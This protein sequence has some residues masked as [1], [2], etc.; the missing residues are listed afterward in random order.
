[1][2][3]LLG[4]VNASVIECGLPPLTHTYVSQTLSEPPC[5]AHGYA[6][7]KWEGI[8]YSDG[9]SLG[10]GPQFSG[11]CLSRGVDLFT[12]RVGSC[13]PPPLS[14][15]IASST[16][17]DLDALYGACPPCDEDISVYTP[18]PQPETPCVRPEG[19]HPETFELIW[20]VAAETKSYSDYS[21]DLI[22]MARAIRKGLK[23][24]YCTCVAECYQ[25]EKPKKAP[26]NLLDMRTWCE[27]R[28]AGID[29][30]IAVLA[31]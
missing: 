6:T 25:Q 31:D 24:H 26:L 2:C 3:C 7:I 1:M 23:P 27:S 29:L 9:G 12:L 28:F 21:W 17:C 4:A 14:L 11:H 20:P 22:A 30:E 19:I 18:T 10:F 13:A 15:L 16:E 5:A 8:Q